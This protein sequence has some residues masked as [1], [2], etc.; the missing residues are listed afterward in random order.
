MAGTSE[1]CSHVGAL[2][3]AA[4]YVTNLKA[5]LSSTDVKAS[6]LAPALKKVPVVPVAEMEWS[7]RAPKAVLTIPEATDED[8]VNF[9]HTLKED[10]GCTA[11]MMR[12]V[13]PFCDE[14]VEDVLITAL[15]ELF[16]ELYVGKTLNELVEIGQQLLPSFTEEE[17]K[18]I[19]MLTRG[20][21]GSS[22]W[23]QQRSG[24]ITA[25]HFRRVCHTSLEKPSL[26]LIKTICYP[27]HGYV[28]YKNNK[29]GNYT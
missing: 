16:D 12:V 18:Q 27:P 20:Q 13:P 29:M 2:L 1:V 9:L 23:F 10:E 8:V 6:W 7:E 15:S 17:Y 19:E 24:R 11:S 4:E 26:S 5:S 22:L 3:F 21:H 25:S 14:E 28:Y